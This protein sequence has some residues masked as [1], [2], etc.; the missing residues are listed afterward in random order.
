VAARARLGVVVVARIPL[1]K[2]ADDRNVRRD[3]G[4]RTTTEE[5]DDDDEAD[6]KLL[7][8]CCGR[9]VAWAN[10]ESGD[11]ASKSRRM[12]II[13]SFSSRGN[14]R[15]KGAHQRNYPRVSA[16]AISL[17]KKFN[18]FIDPFHVEKW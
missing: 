10:T 13:V 5:D 6:D 12:F 14:E 9:T 18:D 15:R 7:D 8:E 1:P 16:A 3:D 11:D 2:I 17:A 4:G